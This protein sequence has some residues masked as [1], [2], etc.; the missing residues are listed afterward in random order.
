[1]FGQALVIED[2]RGAQQWLCSVLGEAFPG[3][4]VS[5]A[6]TAA[7]AR[8][9]LS[10]LQP[11][12]ALVDL[13][14]PDGSGIELL[15]LVHFAN[16]AGI[17]VVT[18]IYDDEPHVFPALRA[19]AQGYLLKDEPRDSLVRQLRALERGELPLSPPI[20]RMVLRHFAPAGAPAGAESLTAKQRAVLAALAEGLTVGQ[21][22]QRLGIARNTVATHVKHVYAKLSISSRAE[23]ARVAARLGLIGD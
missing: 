3:I 9:Q 13:N 18:T 23:A 2:L 15:P 12:L 6:A 20:A 16:P 22:A 7:D 14:L 19:G 11:A 21:A 17:A 10:L 4:A 1:M 8:R 5:L